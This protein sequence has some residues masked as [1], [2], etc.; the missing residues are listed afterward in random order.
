[1]IYFRRI[2]AGTCKWGGP[3]SNFASVCTSRRKWQNIT[4]LNTQ[5]SVNSAVHPYIPIPVFNGSS[6]VYAF[7]VVHDKTIPASSTSHHSYRGN[8]EASKS[9]VDTIVRLVDCR[10]SQINLQQRLNNASSF[11]IT[12]HKNYANYSTEPVITTQFFRN[13]IFSLWWQR[14]QRFVEINVHLLDVD[15][16]L[17]VDDCYY[18]SSVAGNNDKKTT[19]RQHD[20]S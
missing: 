11:C 5:R 13:V 2:R 4:Y 6:V 12:L 18:A 15:L 1:L 16:I 9:H 7:T 20:C 17:T 10:I 19:S 14:M 3:L 8:I